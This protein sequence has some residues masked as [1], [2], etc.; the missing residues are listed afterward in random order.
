[1]RH[2]I[3]YQRTEIIHLEI[4]LPDDLKD[5]PNLAQDW[6]LGVVHRGASPQGHAY[7]RTVT[8]WERSAYS[9]DDKA[10]GDWS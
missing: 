6:A 1:V 8:D 2:I 4:E 10:I 7:K 5:V 9:R 3:E